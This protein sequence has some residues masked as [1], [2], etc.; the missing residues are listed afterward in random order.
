MMRMRIPIPS[1]STINRIDV[2]EIILRWLLHSTATCTDTDAD[3]TD[4]CGVQ[5]EEDDA[6]ANG[7]H[8]KLPIWSGWRYMMDQSL[9]SDS[10]VSIQS[11]R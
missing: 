6:L 8:A 9:F 10:I 5:Q 4:S 2:Y 11:I 7:I 1:I 3:H